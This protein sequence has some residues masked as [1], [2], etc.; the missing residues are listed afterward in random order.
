VEGVLGEQAAA[1][2]EELVDARPEES[3]QTPTELQMSTDEAAAVEHDERIKE[4]RI[5]EFS[6]W[7]ETRLFPFDTPEELFEA[8]K[9]I[10]NEDGTVDVDGHLH[11]QH[12]FVNELPEGFN[13]IHGDVD[14]SDTEIGDLSNLPKHIDGNLMILTKNASIIPRGIEIGGDLTLSRFNQELIDDAKSK[15]YSIKVI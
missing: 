10:F 11:L 7:L 6:E 14:L 1:E 3:A 15:G 8:H 4:R 2:M 13:V 9:Y 12:L 5:R